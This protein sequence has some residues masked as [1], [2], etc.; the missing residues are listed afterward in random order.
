[1]QVAVVIFAVLWF[2]VGISDIIG[3]LEEKENGDTN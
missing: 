3:K 1:M 2:A